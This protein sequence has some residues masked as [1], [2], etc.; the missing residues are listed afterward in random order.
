MTKAMANFPIGLV[1]NM[2]QLNVS[3]VTPSVAPSVFSIDFK[4]LHILSMHEGH[5]QIV[6]AEICMPELQCN[7]SI[8][9]II[10]SNTLEL[11]ILQVHSILNM[12]SELQFNA[13]V[14][15]LK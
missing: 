9:D 11:Y 12:N 2:S 8:L 15:G 10:D 7:Y 1:T 4:L 13:K 5:N 14:I 3:F 6:R